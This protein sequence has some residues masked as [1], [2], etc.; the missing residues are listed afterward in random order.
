LLWFVVN[1]FIFL[2]IKRKPRDNQTKQKNHVSHVCMG[3]KVVC[4]IKGCLR[5]IAIKKSHKN[6]LDDGKR[7]QK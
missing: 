5:N 4:A 6:M 1:L 2:E 7:V 3:F